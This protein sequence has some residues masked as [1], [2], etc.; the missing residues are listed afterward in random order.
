MEALDEDQTNQIKQWVL[1]LDPEAHSK[2][3]AAESLE[4]KIKHFAIL[5]K[6]QSC[7]TKKEFKKLLTQVH[8]EEAK[9]LFSKCKCESGCC[10]K[11]NGPKSQL[12]VLI[13]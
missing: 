5:M 3:E 11:A 2:I 4:E 8:P 13:K 9:I 1:K 10:K 6:D 7:D 12:M